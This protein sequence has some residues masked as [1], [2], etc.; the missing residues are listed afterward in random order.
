MG[1]AVAVAGRAA[2]LVRA[3]PLAALLLVAALAMPAGSPAAPAVADRPQLG[4][5]R[6]LGT[7]VDIFDG[8]EHDDPE[9]AVA[10]MAGRGVRTL[11]LETSNFSQKR[12][13]VYPAAVGR[14]VEAA[15]A[16]GMQVV[17]WYLPGFQNGRLDFQRSRDA[18]RF[19]SPGGERF[20]SFGL[21]IESS[22]VEN[23]RRRNA[24]LL[25]LSRRLRDLVGPGYPLGAII[26]S[27]RGMN[28]KPDYWP[29]FPYEE[30]AAIYDVL[31]PMGYYSYRTE[32]EEDAR[33]YTRRN[34]T[35]IRKQTGMPRVPIHA[36]GG[37]AGDTSRAETR[38]FVHAVREHGLLGGSLYDF[39]TTPDGHWDELASIP[40]NP[41]QSPALPVKLGDPAELGNVPGSDTSHPKEVFYRAGGLPGDRVLEFEAFDIGELE[42]KVLVNWQSLGY[43]PIGASGAWSEESLAVPDGF[44]RDSGPNLVHFMAVGNYPDWSEW[45]VRAVRLTVP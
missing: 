20:D 44:L 15:H 41:V 16:E 5:Y 6:G 13:I 42:V 9:G 18:I 17:A 31:L 22:E 32:T 7:W 38:G 3:R 29:G 40:V 36:I 27:P 23:V 45:G 26:P 8:R 39:G 43:L 11:Y 14:F 25:K 35:I 1:P 4:A 28:L 24:R 37:L 19:R 33:D 21:D 2:T 10:D 12:S 34:V 30:L